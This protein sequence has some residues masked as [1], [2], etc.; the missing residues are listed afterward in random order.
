MK[1]LVAILFLL[2]LSGCMHEKV[3]TYDSTKIITRIG[4]IEFH[5]Y[6]VIT[7]EW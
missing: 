3:I 6:E 4:M 1:T 2:L 5:Q 7:Y